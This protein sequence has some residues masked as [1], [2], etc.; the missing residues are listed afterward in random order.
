MEVADESS[1]AKALESS[2]FWADNVGGQSNDQ[3]DEMRREVQDLITAMCRDSIVSGESSIYARV[4]RSVPASKLERFVRYFHA[5]ASR[6]A[7]LIDIADRRPGSG[8][9]PLSLADVATHPDPKIRVA[10]LICMRHY[11][12]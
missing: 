1:Y 3:P 8:P 7:T 4:M 10:L 12:I 5:Q 6:T 9:G 2:G 11:F